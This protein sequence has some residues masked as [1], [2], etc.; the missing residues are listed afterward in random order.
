LG[1]AWALTAGCVVASVAVP[2]AAGAGS[3]A[4]SEF[5]DGEYVLAVDAGRTLCELALSQS[6]QHF[7]LVVTACERDGQCTAVAL[8][9]AR[10]DRLKVWLS[11]LG[12]EC[13]A[14]YI[15]VGL[16]GDDLCSRQLARDLVENVHSLQLHAR[17]TRR[18]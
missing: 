5:R 11:D 10:G 7:G 8:R 15:R 6:C 2:A 9:N 17:A 13:T 18:P 12:R 1:A 14:V 3:L 16:W 4:Y